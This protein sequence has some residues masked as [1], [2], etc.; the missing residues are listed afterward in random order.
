ME[1]RAAD[2]GEK[3]DQLTFAVM[4]KYFIPL[5]IWYFKHNTSVVQFVQSYYIQFMLLRVGDRGEGV[6]RG[7][8]K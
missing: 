6:V 5:S 3:S 2:A 4:L 7:A 1:V 8:A